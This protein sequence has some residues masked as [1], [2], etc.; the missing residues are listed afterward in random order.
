MSES[1]KPGEQEPMELRRAPRFA[2]FAAL[3]IALGL[4]GTI[5]ATSLFPVD[6]SVGFSVL[7]GYFSLFGVSA[8]LAI[9]LVWWLILD[10]RS[11]RRAR[12][13]RAQKED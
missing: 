6:P 10:W 12:R 9:G 2:P 11:K 3:G 7:V 8:G 4:I 5:I 13:I 1:E